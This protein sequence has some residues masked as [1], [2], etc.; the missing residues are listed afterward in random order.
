MPIL[1]VNN[2]RLIF[3]MRREVGPVR[4]GVAVGPRWYIKAWTNAQSTYSITLASDGDTARWSIIDICK[5]GTYFVI[6]SFIVRYENAS[7]IYDVI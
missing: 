2:C 7:A 6:K 5:V 1:F 4:L 3:G